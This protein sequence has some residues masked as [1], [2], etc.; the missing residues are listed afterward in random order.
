MEGTSLAAKS[1]H[2]QLGLL[3]NVIAPVHRLLTSFATVNVLPSVQR[4]VMS[5][6]GTS[7]ARQN[8]RDIQKSLRDP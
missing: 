6:T 1:Q 7:E 3:R 5:S 8:N 2:R 4:R